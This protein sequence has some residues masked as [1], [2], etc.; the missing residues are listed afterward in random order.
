MPAHSPVPLHLY[1]DAHSDRKQ[2]VTSQ[3]DREEVQTHGIDMFKALY[4]VSY[5]IPLP[6]SY[7]YYAAS[8][9]ILRSVSNINV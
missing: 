6:T 5:P 9:V 1:L 4:S 8:A 2:E 3:R 7:K